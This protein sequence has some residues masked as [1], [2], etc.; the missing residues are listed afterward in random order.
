MCP[1]DTSAWRWN[2][3]RERAFVK[4]SATLLLVSTRARRRR[5]RSIHSARAKYRTSICRVR[6]VG[7]W[8]LPILI[9][10]SLSS[11]KKVAAS[12]GTSRSNKMLRTKRAILPASAAAINSASVED[13]AT[14]ACRRVLY[15]TV[16]PAS[17]ILTPV[18][19]RRVFGQVAKSEST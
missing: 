9:A 18:K 6:V 19:E 12:C 3:I 15:A 1:N 4:L 17:C 5:S 7:F 11:Y 2:R 14:V 13:I 8:A 16:A 10:P